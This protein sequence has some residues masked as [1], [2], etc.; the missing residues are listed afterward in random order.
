M[1]ASGGGV[2]RAIALGVS[3]ALLAFVT[4]VAALVIVV[5]A[6][7]GSAAYT[8]LTSSMAPSLPPGTLVI[9]KPV[10]PDELR[11]GD[12]ITYQLESG[13][14]TVVT[15]RIEQIRSPNLPG[16]ERSFITRGD[17]NGVADA[18]PVRAVQVRGTVW[19]AVPWVGWVNNVIS[20]ERRAILIPIAA[21]ALFG[22]GA[23]MLISHVRDRRRSA[24]AERGDT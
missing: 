11:I 15:H 3:W 10:D 21:V 4:L 23:W 18:E 9:V 16:G 24:I 12:V 2:G 6:V 19:Y 7:T 17:A 13:A 5:P 22:Y 8:I 20:G 1:E 14:S